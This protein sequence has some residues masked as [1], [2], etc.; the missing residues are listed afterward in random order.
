MM[1]EYTTPEPLATLSV[2]DPELKSLIL[3]TPSRPNRESTIEES[4]NAIASSL[5]RIIGN[6][7][8]SQVQ[9]ILMRDGH[10]SEVR[11]YHP[12]ILRPREKTPLIILIHGGGFILGDNKQLNPYARAMSTLLD[13]TVVSFSYCLAP[14]FKFPIAAYDCW[15]SLCWIAKHAAEMGADPTTGFILGAPILNGDSIRNMYDLVGVDV[16]SPDFSPFNVSG[17]QTGMPP[18]YFQVAG[19]EPLRDDGLIYERVLKERGVPTRLRVYPGA[20][21]MDNTLSGR[22]QRSRTS[23][24]LM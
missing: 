14:E 18:T 17:T 21:L 24:I 13:A 23:G 12:E 9:E 2:I 6:V 5:A 22:M 1:R 4:R 20:P 11:I 15:D 8:R 19:A 10:A 16:L 3:A 7:N